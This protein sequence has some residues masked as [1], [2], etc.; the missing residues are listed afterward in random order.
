MPTRADRDEQRVVRKL[1]VVCLHAPARV[2]DVDERAQGEISPSLLAELGQF[3]PVHAPEAK[4]LGN[5]ERSIPEVRLRSDEL[6]IDDR[7]G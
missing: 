5:G 6:D 1:T 4:G 3:E 7:A 2:I